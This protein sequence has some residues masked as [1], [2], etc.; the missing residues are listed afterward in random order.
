MMST[1]SSSQSKQDSD[2][3]Y[4]YLQRPPYTNK[5]FFHPLA[6]I[7]TY[8][9]LQWQP[10]HNNNSHQSTSQTTNSQLINGWQKV[11]TKPHVISQHLTC[12][13]YYWSLLF[14]FFWFL[15]LLIYFDFDFDFISPYNGH[16]LTTKAFPRPQAGHCG[17]V[18]LYQYR[19]SVFLN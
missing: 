2:I 3:Q 12:T 14:F 15:F 10:L 4:V 16:L 1:P 9:Y 11:C 18:P 7:L 13:I 17:G 19:Q 5:Q 6:F 8:R